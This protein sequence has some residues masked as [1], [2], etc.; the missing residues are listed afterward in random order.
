[1][2]NTK[3]H[4]LILLFTL[5]TSLLYAQNVDSLLTIREK[6]TNQTEKYNIEIALATTYSNNWKLDQAETHVN[7]AIILAKSIGDANLQAEASFLSG[8]IFSFKGD[9]QKGDSIYAEALKNAE[10]KELKIKINSGRFELTILTGAVE[11]S[12]SYLNNMREL[13]G[14]DTTSVLMGNYYF[15]SASY[16]G[17]QRQTLKAIKY[18]Q[19]AKKFFLKYNKSVVGINY[20]LATIFQDLKAYE[21]AL[22]V[23]EEMLIDVRKKDNA[24]DELFALYGIMTSYLGLK[25]YEATKRTCFQSIELKE[26]KNVSGVFGYSYY[27]LGSTYFKTDQLDSAEYYFL[28]GIEIS[29]AQNEMSELANNHSGMAELMYKRKEFK[30]AK[31]HGKKTQELVSSI[32]SDNNDILSTIYEKEGRYK[33]AYDLLRVNWEDW[34]KKEEEQ[35]DY[36]VI[37]SLLK[38]KYQQEKEQEQ[39]IFKQKSAKKQGYLILSLLL[40]GLV[41]LGIFSLF[42]IRN[43]RKLKNLNDQLQQRNNALQQF[44]YIA[45]HDIKEPIR[46]IGNHIG[47]IKRKLSKDDQ[48]KLNDYFITIK[49]S[50]EQIYTLIE[51]IMHYTQVSQNSQ[52]E[53]K[54]TDLNKVV[55]NLEVR[56]EPVFE[57]VSGQV[58]YND[59]P[60]I[61][62]SNSILYII[63]KNLIENSLKFNT[64]EIPTVNITCETLSNKHILTVSDNG[65]GI[66]SEYYERIFEM[67]KRLHNKFEYKGSG[68][69]LSIVKLSADRLNAKINLKSEHGKGSQFIIE[70][71][72]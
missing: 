65:I 53:L 47:L 46:S 50:T 13:I 30:K 67:F 5:V 43:N 63:L 18:L 57:S 32:N 24:N 61:K 44:S 7:E 10:H 23:Q 37:A 52:I 26:N 4:Y 17:A 35:T 14:D 49:D 8:R 33:D 19:K 55:K 48:L 54:E 45:S 6:T 27:V 11:K 41:L 2:K 16:Y 25:D 56:L 71:P 15:N 22:E 21:K 40:L 68:I 69:G 12:K 72:A 34:K 36:Q 28:K 38:D 59:L 70:L 39:I 20:N 64:S 42:Q 1:M 9:Y 66:E 3:K 60:T 51:D 31:Y 29:E 62:S 58:I